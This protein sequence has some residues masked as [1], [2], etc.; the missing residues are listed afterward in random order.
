MSVS[1][2]GPY[3]VIR[4]VSGRSSRMRSLLLSQP[5]GPDPLPWADAEST[6]F[7]IS[8]MIFPYYQLAVSSGRA[9]IGVASSLFSTE[10]LNK[11]L[12]D[13]VLLLDVE[14]HSLANAPCFGSTCQPRVH[15]PSSD[16]AWRSLPYGVRRELAALVRARSTQSKESALSVS[17]RC[18]RGKL[19]PHE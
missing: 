19:V 15:F 7:I 17:Y 18:T 10:Q 16:R 2:L 5:S 12:G 14:G 8:I 9:D 1:E 13:E 6:H 11:L 3:Y 4:G